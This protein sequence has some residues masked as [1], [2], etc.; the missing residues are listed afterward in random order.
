MPLITKIKYVNDT[1]PG[2]GTIAAGQTI[3]RGTILNFAAGLLR[4]CAD[5]AGQSFAGIAKQDG[6]GGDKI[7]YEYNHPI[8][9]PAVAAVQADVGSLAYVSGPGTIAKTGTQ[10]IVVGRIVDVEVGVGWY[11]DTS[12]RS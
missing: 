11:I 6:V 2:N 9:Y 8:F 3:V 10:S 7:E 5:T 1:R 4:E 12:L